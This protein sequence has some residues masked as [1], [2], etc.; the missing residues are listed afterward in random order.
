MKQ[1]YFLDYVLV[2]IQFL[3]FG[4][5]LVIDPFYPLPLG[6][7]MWLRLLGGLVSGVG[8]GIVGLAMYTLR[9]ALTAFPTP[10]QNAKLITLGIYKTIRHPIYTGVLAMAFGYACYVSSG[11]KALVALLLLLLFY[12]KT[13]YEEQRLSAVFSEYPQYRKQAGRFLPHVKVPRSE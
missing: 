3:L 6:L 11:T 13:R 9:N 5:Y 12:A 1:S 8:M 2:S 7:P 10:R 4:L